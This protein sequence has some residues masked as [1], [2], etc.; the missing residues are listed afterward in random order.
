M[1][2]T[3][4]LRTVLLD[5]AELIHGTAQAL[6]ASHDRLALLTQDIGETVKGS[7][8]NTPAAATDNCALAARTFAD[9]AALLHRTG[10]QLRAA[11]PGLAD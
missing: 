6:H 10:G 2:E 5:L 8:Q 9:T 4:H 1:T 3:P 7:T 11:L